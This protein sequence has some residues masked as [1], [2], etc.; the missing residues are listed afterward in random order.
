MQIAV[1]SRDMEDKPGTFIHVHV[2]LYMKVK[3]IHKST[4][5]LHTSCVQLCGVFED[6]KL[7]DNHK[8]ICYILSGVSFMCLHFALRE[9]YHWTLAPVASCLAEC[10]VGLL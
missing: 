3:L 5:N 8:L 2:H 10:L 6:T 9:R 4:K 7:M 1:T